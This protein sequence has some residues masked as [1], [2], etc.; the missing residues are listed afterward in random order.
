LVNRQQT[1]RQ[2]DLKQLR[3]V[4]IKRQEH[5]YEFI[6]TESNHCQVLKVIQKVSQHI[7]LFN[8]IF[9]FKTLNN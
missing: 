7:F 2:E 9:V 3:P 4:D 8:K 6:I 5:M 1:V